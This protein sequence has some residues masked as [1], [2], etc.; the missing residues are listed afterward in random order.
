M[1]LRGTSGLRDARVTLE[2]ILE[3][4]SVVLR[5]R[6]GDDIALEDGRV[7]QRAVLG[8]SGRSLTSI[9]RVRPRSLAYF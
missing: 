1:S 7:E 4:L 8:L 5:E 2:Q 3:F 6:E 9:S